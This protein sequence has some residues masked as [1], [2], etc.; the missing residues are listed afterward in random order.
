MT[1]HDLREREQHKGR[2]ERAARHEQHLHTI[3]TTERERMSISGHAREEDGG[4]THP[5]DPTQHAPDAAEDDDA[6][7]READLP[8]DRGN[9]VLRDV[10]ERQHGEH[11][12]EHERHHVR[13]R[14]LWRRAWLTWCRRRRRRA[15][16]D[17]VDDR[18]R[19]ARARVEIELS[20]IWW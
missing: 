9:L 16:Q 20:A 2:P 3:P 1:Y 15:G 18:L 19:E 14:L 4:G 13:V 12:R 11:V 10:H 5:C 17:K 7:E 6:H 8:R